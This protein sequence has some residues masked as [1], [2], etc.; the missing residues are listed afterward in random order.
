MNPFDSQTG[1][2][3]SKAIDD[4]VK[5]NEI[6]SVGFIKMDIEG[7]EL[8]A[9]SG[10]IETIRKHKPK[11]AIALYHSVNDF[12]EIPKFIDDLNLGY[13]FHLGHYTIHSE[14]TILFAS[15]NQTNS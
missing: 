5:E 1:T 3:K 6:E 7:A 12:V 9:L 8:S 15:I 14:E 10:A 11:L 4:F 2:V 13:N